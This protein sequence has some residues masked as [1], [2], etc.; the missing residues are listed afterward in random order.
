MQL[1]FGLRGF[2][3]GGAN[4]NRGYGYR[5]VGPHQ[6][7]E[8]LYLVP[9]TFDSAND[10]VPLGGLTL[11]ETSAELRFPIGRGGLGGA[12]FFDASDVSL[13]GDLRLTRPHLTAGVGLRYAT[14]VGPARL[15]VG[16]RVACAQVFGVCDPQQIHANIPEEAV[17]GELF[18]LPIAVSLAIGEAY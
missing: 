12:I 2:F 17:P 4:S 15:D 10:A 18:G 13:S 6:K 3:S 14:P 9:G 16:Y 11:W 7:V 1:L 5:G 8:S